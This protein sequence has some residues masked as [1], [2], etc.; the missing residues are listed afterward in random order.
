M[1]TGD[2]IEASETEYWME[3][4]FETGYLAEESYKSM[5]QECGAIRRLLISFCKTV[6]DKS[7]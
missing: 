5:Q 1:E 2:V 7:L 6:K 4:L 3:L